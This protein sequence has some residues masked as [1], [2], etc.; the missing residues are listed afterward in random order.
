ME[1]A[2]PIVAVVDDD[3]GMRDSI[4]S[5]L[6]SAGHASALFS[7]ADEFVKA[8]PP[9]ETKCLLLD[10][11]MRGMDGL[12][13]QRLMKTSRPSLPV[14]FVSA[15]Y[16]EG[17][18]IPALNEGAVKFFPKPFDSA[19]LLRTVGECMTP[20]AA[21]AHP[22]DEERREERVRIA[23]ELHDTILQGF[24]GASMQVQT[25]AEGLPENS[26]VKAS[27]TRAIAAMRR[28][29]DEGRR[30]I[31]GFRSSQ[32][33]STEVA[34]LFAQVR[35]EL[36]QFRQPGERPNLRIVREGR[37]KPLR[38]A[39]QDEVY[40]IGREALINALRHA[41]A[42]NIRMEVR[43]DSNS[44]FLI[45]RDDGCG[46]DSKLFTGHHEHWGLSGMREKAERMGACLRMW[47]AP[48]RG[49]DLELKVP[50]SIA[51]AN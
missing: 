44:F 48:G 29:F 32:S 27:L 4:G 38:D 21:A 42:K 45:V 26:P 1:V 9:L 14:I 30:A 39:I 49:T 47:S 3:A 24:S 36:M 25:A 10:V 31:C 40:R 43:Y 37:G 41:H 46:F 8:G 35:D 17:V 7:S 6:K 13:L 28:A 12:Q 11:K 33:P 20:N 23:G 15:H 2:N 34:E 18:R 50:G 5:L 51:F 22:R 19:E 16:D